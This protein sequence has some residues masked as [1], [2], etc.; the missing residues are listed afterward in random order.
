MQIA[1]IRATNKCDFLL[2]Y[3]GLWM[4]ILALLASCAVL[5]RTLS[6]C[7]DEMTEGMAKILILG[8]KICYL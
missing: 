7:L 4:D 2:L 1:Y 6:T 8:K 5:A 3:L